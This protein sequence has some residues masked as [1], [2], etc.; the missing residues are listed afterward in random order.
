MKYRRMITI[1]A[2][3]L[4]LTSCAENTDDLQQFV[5]GVRSQP[6]P[7]I[8]PI[9]AFQTYTPYT[10]IADDR[11]PPFSPVLDTPEIVASG[12]LRPDI[13]RPLEDLEA[14]PLDSLDMVGLLTANGML[15]ALIRAPDDIVYRA[16]VGD[17]AGHDYGEIMAIRDTGIELAEIVPNGAG[18]YMKRSATIPFSQ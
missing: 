9:P 5:T 12:G 3:A 17:H 6:S 7:D 10:Y 15:Y 16:T 18:G 8:E 2:T 4:L 1:G 14:F 13:D 11:R